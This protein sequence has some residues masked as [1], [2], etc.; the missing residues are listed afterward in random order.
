MPNLV[1]EWLQAQVSELM[2]Y[3]TRMTRADFFN[4]LWIRGKK[5]IIKILWHCRFQNVTKDLTGGVNFV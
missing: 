1:Q 2:P 5:N 3:N 4:L